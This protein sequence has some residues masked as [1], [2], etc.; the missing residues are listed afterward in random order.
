VFAQFNRASFTRIAAPT[1]HPN[2]N[3]VDVNYQ[4]L[5]KDK[6]GGA[7][8]EFSETHTM[9]YL[10]L[11]EVEML[12]ESS[13]LCLKDAHE[14]QSNRPLGLDTWTAVFQ[15]AGRNYTAPHLVLFSGS[16]Q[17]ACGGA[18]AASGPFY[19]PQDQRVY[20]DT[21]FFQE[22]RDRLGGVLVVR[23]NTEP[24]A[25]ADLQAERYEQADEEHGVAEPPWLFVANP[26]DREG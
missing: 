21:S 25:E 1:S 20:L 2:Q 22:M 16:V 12:L 11:P 19:C 24:D 3:T 17:S 15:K 5:V 4:V 13:G 18:S 10:F 26:Q 7:L 8:E 23:A 9:R 6:Q 14:F